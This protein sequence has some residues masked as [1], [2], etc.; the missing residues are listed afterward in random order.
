MYIKIKI[1]TLRVES[2]DDFLRRR[3][4]RRRMIEFYQK[5]NNG[6]IFKCGGHDGDWLEMRIP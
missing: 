3:G 1:K 5:E 6:E 4:R 2:W